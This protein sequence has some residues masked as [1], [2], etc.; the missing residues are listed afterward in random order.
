MDKGINQEDLENIEDLKLFEDSEFCIR[1]SS[2]KD[3]NEYL[4]VIEQSISR[5]YVI[6][7]KIIIDQEFNLEAATLI[8]TGAYRNIIREWLIPTS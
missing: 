6:K 8:D 4:I 2:K 1:E 3:A 7:I 5:R